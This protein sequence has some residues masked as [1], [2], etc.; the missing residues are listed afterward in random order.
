MHDQKRL[1]GVAFPLK[2]ASLDAVH[3]KN[4][5][6][7]HISTLHIWPARRPLAAARAAL[8]A[9][10][11]PDPGDDAARQALLKRLG[12]EVK[13]SWKTQKNGD[14]ALEE[15][16]VE[17]TVGGILHWGR[18]NSPDLAWFREQIRTACGGRARACSTPLPAAA[19]FRSKPCAWA[20]R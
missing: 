6:H 19:R 20:A 5:R 7:G 17:E 10:L 9:T 11:L 14:G 4:M 1:I 13:E 8:A 12:G 18:E 2:Q 15:Q 3:E 16:R